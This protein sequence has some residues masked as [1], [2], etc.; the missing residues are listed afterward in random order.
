MTQPDTL[1]SKL[2]QC[3]KYKQPKIALKTAREKIFPGLCYIE[4]VVLCSQKI[5][6]TLC[7]TKNNKK[8]KGKNPPKIISF[9]NRV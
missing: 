1:Q 3:I 5:N 7:I 9:L 8:N 2:F 6:E 4:S